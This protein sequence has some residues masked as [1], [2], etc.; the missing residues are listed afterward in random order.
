MYYCIFYIMNILIN[1]YFLYFYRILCHTFPL[2]LCESLPFSYI[3]RFY[4]KL[5]HLM[6]DKVPHP[7][8]K[9]N[10]EGKL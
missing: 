2:I 4:E 9:H 8:G 3:P 6:R 7:I 1:Y 5:C 10:K